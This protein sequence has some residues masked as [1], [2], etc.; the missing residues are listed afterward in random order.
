[1]A[2]EGYRA[3]FLQPWLL[4]KLPSHSDVTRQ[5]RDMN[6]GHVMKMKRNSLTSPLEETAENLTEAGAGRCLQ[7]SC[8]GST[9]QE[10][11]V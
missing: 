10:Q 3:S 4:P 7:G 2:A 5:V 6:N 11:P 9:I 8:D 1:M